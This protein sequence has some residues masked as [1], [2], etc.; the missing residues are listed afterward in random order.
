MCESWK[1]A[2]A[3]FPPGKPKEAI[4]PVSTPWQKGWTS[5]W[6]SLSQ[7]DAPTQD[8][9]LENVTERQRDNE[10]RRME[11]VVAAPSSDVLAR[12]LLLGSLPW[13]LPFFWEPHSQFS[14]WF[15]ALA[16]SLK[17][18]ISTQESW[19]AWAT[20][21]S[22]QVFCLLVRFGNWNPQLENEEGSR[23]KSEY[24]SS[25]FPMRSPWVGCSSLESHCSSQSGLFYT[26]FFFH[27]LINSPIPSFLWAKG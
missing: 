19:F 25:W 13:A 11:K 4:F 8:F 16:D 17:C 27:V 9:G 15:C 3:Q 5:E 12:L 24:L 1:K 26:V 7:S 6:T 22:S 23:A 21:V 18:Y 20:S 10:I 14:H 2:A